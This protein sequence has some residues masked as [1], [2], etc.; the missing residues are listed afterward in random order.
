MAKIKQVAKY[1][2]SS[3]GTPYDLGAD[4]ENIDVVTGEDPTTQEEITDNLQNVIDNIQEDISDIQTDLNNKVDTEDLSGFDFT[5]TYLETTGNSA[6]TIVNGISQ[7]T[8][9]SSDIATQAQAVAGESTLTL[10]NKFNKFVQ[11]VNNKFNNYVTSSTLTNELANKVSKAGDTMTNSLIIK[12]S[13]LDSSIVPATSYWGLPDDTSQSWNLGQSVEFTDQNDLNV[14]HIRT[15]KT[16]A[17]S[18][19]QGIYIEGARDIDGTLYQNAL[20]IGVDGDGNKKVLL[21]STPWMEALGAVS[22]SGDTITGD[23]TITKASATPHVYLKNESMDTTAA[24]IAQTKYSGVYMYDKNNIFSGYV[25]SQQ[26]PDGSVQT[27]MYARRRNTDNTANVQNGLSLNIKQDGTKAVYLDPDPWLAALQAPKVTSSSPTLTTG[28]FVSAGTQT[29]SGVYLYKVGRIVFLHFAVT[30]GSNSSTTNTYI[31]GDK[32]PVTPI[33]NTIIG[34]FTN[35][36]GSISGYLGGHNTNTWLSK[37]GTGRYSG[38]N[39]SGVSLYFSMI[40][41]T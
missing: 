34:R 22:K 32:L 19:T 24:S 14:G 16:N 39:L 23:L 36:D 29:F 5:K 26:N 4:A 35:T 27:N 21:S 30:F 12:N 25:E 38:T 37:N 31:N 20:R 40:Y 7:N 33:A 9:T 6:N 41:L 15:F 13:E 10:W 17:S 8:D 18:D 11:R 3:W 2:G 1:D 28:L